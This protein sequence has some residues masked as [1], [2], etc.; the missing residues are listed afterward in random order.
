MTLSDRHWIEETIENAFWRLDNL[1]KRK[2]T[3]TER[4]AFKM[5]LRGVFAEAQLRGD[6]AVAELDELR[7]VTLR[8]LNAH[9]VSTRSHSASLCD[10]CGDAGRMLAKTQ[11]PLSGEASAKTTCPRCKTLFKPGERHGCSALPGTPEEWACIHCKCDTRNTGGHFSVE[12]I[13][14]GDCW[15]ARLAAEKLDRWASR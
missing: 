3:M 13:E 6:A 11:H 9:H 4:D 5:V 10:L 2:A 14:C 12:G 8:L 7:A 15:N 1:N